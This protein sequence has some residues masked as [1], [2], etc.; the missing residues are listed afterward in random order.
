[1]RLID[2]DALSAFVGDLRSTLHKEQSTFKAMTQS[3]FEIKDNMLLNF[4]YAID[5]A[6]T[7]DFE[8][9]GESLRCQI[10]AE[11]GSC[12]GCELSCPRNELINLLN[13]E[14]PQGEWI[15]RHKENSFGQDVVCFECNKCGEYKLPIIHTMITEPLGVC[16]NCGADMRGSN[17]E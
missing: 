11:Y 4:Q 12:D 9:L 15:T 13:L 3:E 7:V 10:R 1:M 5:N 14:R 6:P 2:A 8:K 17:N 16:P